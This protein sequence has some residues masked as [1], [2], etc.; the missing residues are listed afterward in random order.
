MSVPRYSQ[1]IMLVA[2][3]VSGVVLGHVIRRVRSMAED[4]ARRVA[5]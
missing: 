5:Q 2:L 4:F 1:L 3:L